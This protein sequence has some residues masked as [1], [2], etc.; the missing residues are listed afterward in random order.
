MHEG[1]QHCGEYKGKL[2]QPELTL[3]K[4]MDKESILVDYVFL[5]FEG[6][7]LQS[8][9]SCLISEGEWIL[10]ASSCQPGKT[11]SCRHFQDNNYKII[12]HLPTSSTPPPFSCLLKQSNLQETPNKQKH[13]EEMLCSASCGVKEEDRSISFHC[14]VLMRKT[15]PLLF[16]LQTQSTWEAYWNP[17]M[18]P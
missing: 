6:P 14:C 5:A 8:L 4:D 7:I 10:K 11:M 9:S 17:I 15:I 2:K 1:H 13:L 3:K 18:L 12:K 16:I